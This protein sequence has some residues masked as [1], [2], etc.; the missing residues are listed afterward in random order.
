MWCSFALLQK[1]SR[2]NSYRNTVLQESQSVLCEGGE[3]VTKFYSPFFH[4]FSRRKNTYSVLVL[5]PDARDEV[6]AWMMIVVVDQALT[7]TMT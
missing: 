6:D 5:M 2:S 4:R 7:L 1:T 3:T